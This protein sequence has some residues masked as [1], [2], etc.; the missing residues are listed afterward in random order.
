MKFFHQSF[1]GLVTNINIFNF[2][3]D[4]DLRNMSANPCLY[5]AHGDLLSWD[6]INWESDGENV[7]QIS[8]EEE[9]I[10]GRE[11]F[12]NVPLLTNFQLDTANYACRVLGDG[13]IAQIRDNQEMAR[14]VELTA[15][16]KH[17]WTP[18]SDEKV[19]DSF[20]N[21]YDG[22]PM[23]NLPWKEGNPNLGTSGNNV[24]L[25]AQNNISGLADAT[26]YRSACA[27]CNI[28]KV[29]KQS[30]NNYQL[31]DKDHSYILQ[32]TTFQLWGTCKGSYLGRNYD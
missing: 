3:S 15:P 14:L 25:W 19:E 8:W 10:C 24:L 16:C 31:S 5:A 21:I 30:T 17:T 1:G 32:T 6:D 2:S 28:S 27:V 9:D 11:Q 4:H 29:E 22:Q 12:Y 20:V 13:R 23:P 26:S 18:Y 7:E